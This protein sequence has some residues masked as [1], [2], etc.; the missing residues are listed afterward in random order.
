[1]VGRPQLSDERTF[2]AALSILAIAVAA[3]GAGSGSDPTERISEEVTWADDVA[4]VVYRECVGCHRPEG[5][6][7]FSLLTYEDASRRAAQMARATLAETMPPWPPE[8]E[9]GTFL[10]ERRLSD[11]EIA[12]FQRW[13]ESGAPVGDVGEAP[14]PPP[15]PGSWRLGEPDLVVDFPTYTLRANGR[16]VF[17]NLVAAAP[18]DRLRYVSAVELDPGDPRTV[19]HAVMLVDT[20]N[21]S[22]AMAD[23]HHAPGFDN[24]ETGTNATSPDGHVVGWTPGKGALPPLEGTAW[25]LEPGTDLVLKLHLRPTGRAER[26]ESRVGLHFTETPPGKRPVG[27]VLES[28]MIDIPAGDPEYRVTTNYEL[29]VAVDVLSVYPH[30]HYLG[31]DLRGFATLPDGTVRQLIHIPN[32]DFDWQDQYRFVDPVR[33]PAGTVLTLDYTFDN[34]AENP[35]NP[36]DPPR[37]VTYGLSSTDEMAQL[38]LQVLPD[39]ASDRRILVADE[40]RR[41]RA[42]SAAYVATREVRQGDRSL[43]EGDPDGAIAHY[44][45]AI[46]SRLDHPPALVGLTRAFLAKGDFESA[47]LAGERAARITERRDP[48]ALSALARAYAGLA[49]A[50]AQSVAEEALRLARQLGRS[51]LADSIRLRLADYRGLDR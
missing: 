8:S 2:S 9:D 44:R 18:V 24:M 33:L 5:R 3:S 14:S 11:E 29:P 39:D 25:R 42:E 51:E 1:M 47:R 12:L 48:A 32:W 40:R 46:Q 26:V 35:Q 6:G 37:R 41:H 15:P 22:R 4:P 50:R 20:T 36:N 7:P 13:A 10:G 21:S 43:E 31:K 38:I 34:S 16:D 17:R 23:R 19:H 45:R 28:A 27:L 49:D 30:A